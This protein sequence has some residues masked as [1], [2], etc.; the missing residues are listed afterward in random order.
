MKE[1]KKRR[2]RKKTTKKKRKE[3]SHSLSFNYTEIPNK[4]PPQTYLF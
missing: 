4:L 3:K 1:N 2:K